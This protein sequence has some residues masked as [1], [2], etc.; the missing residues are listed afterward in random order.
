[1]FVPK[2]KSEL[3]QLV[4]EQAEENLQLEFKDARAL[5]QHDNKKT[6]IS[7][8]VSAMANSAGGVI[9]YGIA[10]EAHHAGRITCISRRDFSKE[11]LDQIILSSIHPKIE[12]LVIHPVTFGEDEVVYVVEI[13][14]ST[15][16]HQAKDG[17]YHR[18]QN[19]VTAWMEDYEI[20]DVMNRTRHPVIEIAMKII[21]YGSEVGDAYGI[22]R[23]PRG[24][25]Y[26]HLQ[27]APRIVVMSLRITL[28]SKLACP[29]DWLTMVQNRYQAK[30]L[31]GT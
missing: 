2:T 15:T 21:R 3:E 16:A 6:E 27:I 5:N 13:P 1:M 4:A 10:E 14:Q 12:G 29:K 25:V 18:R 28:V 7:K 11:W 22:Q 31:D 24:T 8:D 20:R 30:T 19:S 9:I 23:R 26:Y 17:R